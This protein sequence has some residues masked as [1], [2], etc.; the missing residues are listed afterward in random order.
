MEYLISFSFAKYDAFVWSFIV[1]VCRRTQSSKD[2]KQ[3]RPKSGELKFGSWLDEDTEGEEL[4]EEFVKDG[5]PSESVPDFI[6]TDG[7]LEC[8]A[9]RGLS[10]DDQLTDST[11][12]CTL[13]YLNFAK[14]RL[15]YAYT[16]LYV[17]F[18]LCIL[19]YMYT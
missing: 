7:S 2:L 16:L 11:E 10:T 8:E 12:V 13:L 4:L 1:S 6:D 9:G 17:H 18:A 14:C 15:C 19:Y 3:F 5:V